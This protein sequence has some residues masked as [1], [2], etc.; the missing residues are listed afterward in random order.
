MGSTQNVNIPKYLTAAH[1]SLS[2]RG[3]SNKAN[4]IALSDNL[5][6]RYYLC[7]IDRQRYMKKSVKTNFFENEY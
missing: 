2:R 4:E 7:G 3:V 5:D 6:V 1:Q